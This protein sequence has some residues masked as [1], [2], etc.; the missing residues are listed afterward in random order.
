MNDRAVRNIQRAEKKNKKKLCN[1][2][3]NFENKKKKKS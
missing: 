3:L 1:K 2:L